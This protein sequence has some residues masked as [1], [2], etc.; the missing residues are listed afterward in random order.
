MLK[1]FKTWAITTSNSILTSNGVSKIENDQW[2]NVIVSLDNN[3]M[4]AISDDG[5]TAIQQPV[6]PDVIATKN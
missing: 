2:G 1:G 5:M 4:I 6:L 3:M